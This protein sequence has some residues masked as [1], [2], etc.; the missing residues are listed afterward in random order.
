MT[1]DV[2][3]RDV[4]EDDLRTL[5]EQQLDPAA[6]YMA[7]FGAEDP[8]DRNA[9]MAR[10]TKILANAT[11]NA[12][13]AQAILSGGQVA[14]SILHF[15]MFGVPS[16]GYWLGKPYWGKGIATQALAQFLRQVTT[17]PL[18]ARAATDNIASIRVLQKC[19]FTVIGT[20]KG[21]SHARG[22]DVEETILRLPAAGDT[23]VTDNAP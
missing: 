10:W 4:T 19:G 8:A 15:D 1:S 18:Y 17:R 9:F 2:R 5:F 21:F 22:M 7:A 12:H 14:G 11:I 13:N 3:L 23:G 16:V 6:N 20:D